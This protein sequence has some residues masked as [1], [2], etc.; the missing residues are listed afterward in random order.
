MVGSTDALE[1]AERALNGRRE[2]A[3]ISFFHELLL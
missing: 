3:V 2:D 1:N